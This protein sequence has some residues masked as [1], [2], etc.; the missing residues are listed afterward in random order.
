MP[1]FPRT[2]LTSWHPRLLRGGALAA[3]F[4]LAGC[5]QNLN[6]EAVKKSIS[7]GLA[8]QLG[9]QVASLECPPNR[10]VKAGDAFECVATPNGGG[11]LTVKV[12]Q[13]DDASNVSWEVVKT[14]GLLDLG[15][16]EGSIR[17]SLKEQAKVEATVACGGRWKP[18]KAGDTFE[19]QA[20]TAD[21][22]AVPIVVSVADNDGNINWK[23]K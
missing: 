21:G 9:L 18:A 17:T 15:K 7:D 23:T 5:T 12:S 1:F 13:K 19:C 11:R 22:Q 16:V 14:E 20:K 6:M 8:S 3:V 2:P 4:A 10:P